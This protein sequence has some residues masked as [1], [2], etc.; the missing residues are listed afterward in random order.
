MYAPRHLYLASRSLRRRELLK[1]IGVGFELLLL[2]E[3]AGRP[4]DVDEGVQPG[5]DP[6]AYVQRLA[7]EKADIAWL[8]L[9]HRR[10]MRHPVLTADTT[11]SLQGEILGK[12]GNR[13]EAV[14]MLKRLSGTTHEVHTAVAVIFDRQLETAL[15]ST[16]VSFAELSD[17]EINQYVASGDPMDKAGAYGIQG[18]AGAYVK[19]LSGSYTGVVGLPLYETD[20]LLRRFTIRSSA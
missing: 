1:Q 10:L 13:D 6:M 20:Q 7:R 17:E 3:A 5:E 15:S 14:S 4:P 2:R 12:P 18:R 11:V 8:R 9:C 16:T 19:S